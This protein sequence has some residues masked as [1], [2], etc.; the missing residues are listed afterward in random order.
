MALELKSA[1]LVPAKEAFVAVSNLGTL[2]LGSF[3]LLTKD[4]CDRYLRPF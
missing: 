2:V 1:D 4:R 3:V